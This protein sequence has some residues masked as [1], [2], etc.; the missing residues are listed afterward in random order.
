VFEV[1]R[2]VAVNC[3][4]LEEGRVIDE[5]A[6]ETFTGGVARVTEKSALPYFPAESVADAVKGN[7]PMLL[8]VPLITPVALSIFSPGGRLEA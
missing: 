4:V 6:T 1:Y 5:G 3:F 2:T 8:L 7:V